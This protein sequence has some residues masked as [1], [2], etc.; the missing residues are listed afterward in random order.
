MKMND[1]VQLT[2]KTGE[3]DDI[4]NI[5]VEHEWFA[6]KTYAIATITFDMDEKCVVGGCCTELLAVEITGTGTIV[7]ADSD[8]VTADT[9]VITADAE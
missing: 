6:E 7:S 3:V 4:Y 8:V 1:Y 9:T 2:W 5:S